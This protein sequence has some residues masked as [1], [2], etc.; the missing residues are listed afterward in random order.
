[1]F[2]VIGSIILVWCMLSQLQMINS[3]Y[4]YALFSCLVFLV[5][6]SHKSIVKANYF[7]STI[8][9]VSIFTNLFSDYSYF[10]LVFMLIYA[11][12]FLTL[13]IKLVIS[14]SD[15]IFL[16]LFLVITFIISMLPIKLEFYLTLRDIL[17]SGITSWE[18]NTHPWIF[19]LFFTFF[20]RTGNRRYMLLNLIFLFISFKRIVF[21]GLIAF[22]IYNRFYNK[23]RLIRNAV[24]IPILLIPLMPWF[25]LS[26]ELASWVTSATGLNLA[27]VTM[28]RSAFYDQIIQRYD[29]GINPVGIGKV[30]EYSINNFNYLIHNDH[31]K[32]ILEMGLPLYL[33]AI[34]F[35][36]R[37]TDIAYFAVL[38]VLMATDN[39]IIYFYFLFFFFALAG[40]WNRNNSAK[41]VV[42]NI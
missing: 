20:Y 7:V 31:L 32:L 41:N 11:A 25:L 22:I 16:N 6:F 28:G 35:L 10:S 38:M 4:F 19:L 39:V 18:N 40:F 17:T 37:S 24:T 36:W 15:V 14:E 2:K 21:I 30:T 8:L 26:K 13:S 3:V 12:L 34:Y 33:L 9:I 1:M 23:N 5:I 27:H 29:I 42:F